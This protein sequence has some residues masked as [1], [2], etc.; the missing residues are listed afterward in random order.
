M[1]LGTEE[2]AGIGASS[3]PERSGRYRS[4]TA[5]APLQPG[6]HPLRRCGRLLP[7]VRRRSRR[8]RCGRNRSG[9]NRSGQGLHRVH[10]LGLHR[11]GRDLDDCF[12]SSACAGR[13]DR[14]VL[15]D[16]KVHLQEVAAQD[17]TQLHAALTRQVP[18]MFGRDQ[19]LDGGLDLRRDIVHV[20]GEDPHL[21]DGAD[22]ASTGDQKP[23][24]H[25]EQLLRN[26]QSFHL[27]GSAALRLLEHDV[28]AELGTRRLLNEGHGNS[29]Q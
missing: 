21:R 5:E 28:A 26:D 12:E 23:P 17:A 13:R 19:H 16:L 29:L 10:R 6:E 8:N 1:L 22:N 11:D 3:Q 18:S 27:N 24:R 20:D 9:Q 4:R 2:T 14:S 7:P 25:D 15:D